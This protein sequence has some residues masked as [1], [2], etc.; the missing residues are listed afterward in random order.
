MTT[1]NPP[2]QAHARKQSIWLGIGVAWLVQ[3]ALKTIL[4]MLVLA[5][6]RYWSL[7]ADRPSLWLEDPGNSSHPVWYALQAAVFFGS[8]LAGS[9]TAVLAPRRSSAVPVALVMLSL[10]TTAFEQFPRPLSATVAVIWTAAPCLGLVLGV[11]L[12]RR[13]TRKAAAQ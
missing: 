3:L 4:P 12:G 13:F 2:H 8:V 5:G 9:L 1:S 11:M 10:L 7:A 6:V